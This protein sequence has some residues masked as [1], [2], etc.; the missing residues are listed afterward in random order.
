MD[1]ATRRRR[2][3]QTLPPKGF[4]VRAVQDPKIE[5]RTTMILRMAFRRNTKNRGKPQ[6]SV[7]NNALDAQFV[8]RFPTGTRR[9]GPRLWDHKDSFAH[10]R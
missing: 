10:N 3:R 6:F 4:P 2:T 9:H 8:H 1:R 7:H 5:N